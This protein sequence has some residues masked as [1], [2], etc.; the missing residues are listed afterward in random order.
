MYVH[1]KRILR[2]EMCK[3]VASGILARSHTRV[4][5]QQFGAKHAAMIHPKC[6]TRLTPKRAPARAPSTP[7][8]QVAPRLLT[9]GPAACGLSH[10]LGRPA[11]PASCCLGH[12]P[13]RWRYVR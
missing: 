3:R 12:P 13:I 10:L 11:A 9:C 6:V 8:E 5:R 7:S 4:R 1:N 2:R